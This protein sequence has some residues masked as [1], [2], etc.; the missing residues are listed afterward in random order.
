MLNQTQTRK[1]QS[2]KS[3]YLLTLI[4][5]DEEGSVIEEARALLLR[6]ANP[7][8]LPPTPSSY[9]TPSPQNLLQGLKKIII[10]DKEE[11]GTLSSHVCNSIVFHK[12]PY[13]HHKRE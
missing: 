13:I 11:S 12:L 7:I 5:Q 1:G 10:F 4:S 6:A 9:Y 8:N 2:R 3:R